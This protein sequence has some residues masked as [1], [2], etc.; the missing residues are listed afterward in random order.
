MASFIFATGIENSYPTVPTRDGGRRRVDEME[1]TCHYKRWREDFH[2]TKELGIQFLRYGPPYYRTHA[3]PGKYDWDFADET[4]AALRKLGIAPIVDLCHFGV[5]DWIGDFQNADWPHYFAE[6]ARAFAE[7]F[8]WVRLYTP[9]NEIFVTATFSAKNGWWN[10]ALTSERA[11]VAAMKNLCKANVLAMKRILEV[12]PEAIFIQSESSEYFHAAEPD[13]ANNADFLNEMR[14]LPFDLS[15]GYAVSAEMYQYLLENGMTR[16]EYLWFQSS[17]LR[18]YCVMGNDYYAANEHM[19]HCDGSVTGS[20]EIFGY[21]VITNQYYGRYRIPVMHTETNTSDNPVWWLQKEWANLHRLKVDGVPVLGFTWYS[22]QDQVD[23][24]TV[25]RE[26]NGNV[27][28]CGLVS[29][30]R[31]INPV[32]HAY[33]DLAAKWRNILPMESSVLSLCV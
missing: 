4:F 27:N 12:Q 7:R 10:E 18:Q 21:Y 23:W 9:V 16:E 6:Y 17:H 11:F 2:L 19:V 14:F 15:Y 1:K 8:R 24:D 30:D 20:G 5:P 25:L 22:L 31:Q 26:D 33:R 13:C 28:H 3:G 32:G 29:L